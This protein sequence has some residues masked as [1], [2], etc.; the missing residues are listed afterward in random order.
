MLR[1]NKCDEKVGKDEDMK[2]WMKKGGK[3]YLKTR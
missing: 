3:M 2:K 1:E